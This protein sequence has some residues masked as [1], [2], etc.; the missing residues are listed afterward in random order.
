MTFTAKAGRR[1]AGFLATA[2]LLGGA[3]AQAEPVKI[4]T[5]V[6]LTGPG[7]ASGEPFKDGVKLAVDEINASG[8]ILGDQIEAPVLDSQSNPLIAKAMATKAVDDGAYAIMGPIFSGSVL[9]SME[10]AREAHVP[11]FVGGEASS[12]TERGNPYVFRTS[13]SQAKAMPKAAHYMASIAPGK[14]VGIVYVN[15]DFGKGGLDVIAPTLKK[16]GM[17]IAVEVPT[18]QGQLDFSSPVLQLTR[19]KADLLFAYLNVEESAR[20]LGELKKQGWDKPIIGETTIMQ[21]SVIDL[22][23]GAAEGARGHVGLTIDAPNPL[24]RDFAQRFEKTYGYKSSHDGLKG[25]TGMYIL[26]AATERVGR[27][28]PEA[29]AAM[30]KGLSLS[31]K[32]HPGILMDVH[33]DDKGDLAR[34]SYVVEVQDGRQVVIETLPAVFK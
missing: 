19:S 20:L 33:Y 27:I 30:M 23:G 22:A 12:I 7:A 31:A 28:D 4:Y 24:V 5:I 25:Y 15:N 9:V 2:A 18:S 10:V 13:F 16:L 8:G 17:P 26:K 3:P 29:L 21:Q 6:E 34:E 14:S 11:N 32:D 1:L